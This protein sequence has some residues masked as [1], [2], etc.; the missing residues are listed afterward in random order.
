MVGDDSG[1]IFKIMAN[2][3][4]TVG[5]WS[6]PKNWD[7]EETKDTTVSDAPPDNYFETFIWSKE[8]TSLRYT[9]NLATTIEEHLEYETKM[10]WKNM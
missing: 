1:R 7:F 6:H 2:N 5:Y 9:G 10:T 8:D 3:P 4:N